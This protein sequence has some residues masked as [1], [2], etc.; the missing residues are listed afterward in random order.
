MIDSVHARGTY[1][2]YAEEPPWQ[3]VHALTTTVIQIVM[4]TLCALKAVWL[5]LTVRV[6]LTETGG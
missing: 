1:E 5:S 4:C 3:V 6:I 2:C